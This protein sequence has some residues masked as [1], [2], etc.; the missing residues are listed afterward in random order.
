MLNLAFGIRNSQLHRVRTTK[1]C[2]CFSAGFLRTVTA[3]WELGRIEKG[4]VRE[5]TKENRCSLEGSLSASI[6]P[7][8]SDGVLFCRPGWEMFGRY[9]S[10]SWQKPIGV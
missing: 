4:F 7:K 10:K 2:G 8:S 9:A 5:K 3:T 1:L 6:D